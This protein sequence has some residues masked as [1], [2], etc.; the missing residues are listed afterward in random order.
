MNTITKV[1]VGRP[2][3]SN[4][5]IVCA[6]Q[7]EETIAWSPFV[8]QALKSD[9]WMLSSTVAQSAHQLARTQLR[10]QTGGN[11]F[12]CVQIASGA[13]RYTLTVYSDG[14]GCRPSLCLKRVDYITSNL[15]C[16]GGCFNKAA[17]QK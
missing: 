6:K 14:I 3:V 15:E 9:E 8:L 7:A 17:M 4:N 2:N 11:K 5:G 13:T 1:V 16:I 10:K 12:W